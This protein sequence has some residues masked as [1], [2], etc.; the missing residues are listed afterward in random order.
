MVDLHSILAGHTSKNDDSNL[1]ELNDSHGISPSVSEIPDL[2]FD[3]IL[4]KFKLSRVEIMVLMYL[5][6]RV[7]CRPNL[8]KM[9]GISQLMSHTDMANNLSLPLEDVY[10]AL[11]N[12]EDYSFISTIRS[13]QYFVRKY[14]THENDDNFGQTYDDFEI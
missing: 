1:P 4:P 2:F 14:F 11:R 7:W 5:Y 12:L 10:H 6:R 13:G 8:Y 3:S 9:H